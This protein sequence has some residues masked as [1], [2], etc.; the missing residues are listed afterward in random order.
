[1]YFQ[2]ILFILDDPNPIEKVIE[3]FHLTKNIG[4]LSNSTIREKNPRSMQIQTNIY[5]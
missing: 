2:K 4:P 3:L 5:E 1:M